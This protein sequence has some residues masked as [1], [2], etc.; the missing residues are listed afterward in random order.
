MQRVWRKPHL[1][2]MIREC[3]KLQCS[4]PFVI[5]FV[6]F[7][8]FAPLAQATDYTSTNFILRDPVITVEGGYA[9]STNFQFFSSSGQ[10]VIGENTSTS[11]TQRAGFLYFPTATTSVLAATAGNGQV[12]LSWTAAVGSLGNVTNYQVG[13]ATTSGGS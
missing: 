8:V 7:S 6:F 11:F 1:F 12:S 3:M 2:G 5:L 10:T 13:T 9:S 4:R